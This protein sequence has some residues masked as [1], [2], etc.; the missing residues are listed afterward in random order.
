MKKVF[1]WCSVHQISEAQTQELQQLG[2]EELLFLPAELQARINNCP[3]DMG[4]IKDLREDLGKYLG[5]TYG[6]NNSDLH[7]VQL[8]GSP[9]FHKVWGALSIYKGHNE[10]GAP[11]K[12]V[13]S[14]SERVSEDIPQ[15]DGSVKKVSTFRHKNFM[16]F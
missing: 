16:V 8:G 7:I 4:G 14:Y 15:E 5:V 9:M 2:M 12:M 13:D 10:R 3:G 6:W 1:I 11:Y